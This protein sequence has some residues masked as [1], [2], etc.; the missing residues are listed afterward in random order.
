MVSDHEQ[1][2]LRDDLSFRG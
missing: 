1:V 2:H